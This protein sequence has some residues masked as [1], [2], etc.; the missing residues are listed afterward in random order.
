[1]V[2]RP[3]RNPRLVVHTTAAGINVA[4]CR[5]TVSNFDTAFTDDNAAAVLAPLSLH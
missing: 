5:M 2:T 1:M 3:L 4:R